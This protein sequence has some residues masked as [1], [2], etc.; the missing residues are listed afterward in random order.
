[1]ERWAGIVS[2]HPRRIILAWVVFTGFLLLFARS[3]GGELTDA[4]TLPG[5]E[6]QR[7]QD[8][9]S[10]VFPSEAGIGVH[11]V[12]RAPSGSIDQPR[13]REA[14]EAFQRRAGRVD[15]VVAVENAW[16]TPG[17]FPGGFGDLLNI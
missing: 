1:M 3:F 17:S 12:F 8:L 7:A 6:S 5:A 16:E 10:E 15:E 11:A 9:L 2:R 14:I 4:F 13:Y